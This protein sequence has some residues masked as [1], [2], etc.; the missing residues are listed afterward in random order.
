M[1]FS[2][3]NTSDHGCYTYGCNDSIHQN[4]LIDSYTQNTG[5]LTR[6]SA[7]R[8]APWCSIIVGS[9]VSVG[10]DGVINLNFKTTAENILPWLGCALLH[11]RVRTHTVLTCA[12]MPL[13][14]SHC[15]GNRARSDG[16]RQMRKSSEN[17]THRRHLSASTVL[18]LPCGFGQHPSG[19][20]QQENLCTHT[21][22][23]WRGVP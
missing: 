18:P 17:I 21:N 7:R 19:V 1:A 12:R 10:V 5:K 3:N 9:A 11:T 23:P 15:F 22:T 2:Q 4:T 13:V 8:S 6:R 20:P 14:P 16:Y